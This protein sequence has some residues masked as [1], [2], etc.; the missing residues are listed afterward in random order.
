V[1]EAMKTIWWDMDGT[2]ADLYAVENWLPKLRA[3]DPTPYAEAGVLWNMSQ[4]ARLMNQVQQLG[5][6]LGIIS[7]TSKGGSASYNA[8]V[9]NAK[10]SWLKRHLASVQFDEIYIVKYGTPKSIVMNTE[11]DVLFDDEEQNRDHWLG[12]AYEPNMMIKVLKALLGKM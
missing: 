4:L 12:E 6:K 1:Q 8:E 9:A 10:A 7:W 3:E 2:I 5:Y 11:D